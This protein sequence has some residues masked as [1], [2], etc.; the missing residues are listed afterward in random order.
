MPHLSVGLGVPV[1]H[2]C[3]NILLL[4]GFKKMKEIITDVLAAAAVL[5]GEA[6]L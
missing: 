1:D 2:Y 4:E 5:K 3:S 6:I